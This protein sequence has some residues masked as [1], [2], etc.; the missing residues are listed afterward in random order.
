V[1]STFF[2]HLECSVPCGA[3]PCDPRQTHHRCVCGAPLLARY[4]LTAARRW[5]KSTL[6]GRESSMWRYREILPLLVSSKGVD[7]PVSLGEGWTPLLRARRLGATL[8]LRRLYI[9]DEGQNPTGS[10]KARGFSAAMTRALH[11]GAKVVTVATAGHGAAAA[12]AYAAKAAL[13]AKATVPRDGRRVFELEAGLLRVEITRVDGQVTDAERIVAEQAAANGWYDLSAFREPYRLEGQKTIG[14]ELAEQLG[15]ELPDWILCPVGSGAAFS[16]IWKAFTEMAS[17]GWID[18]VRRPHMVAVQAA[19]CAPIVR[20][21]GSGADH[22][23]AW[24]AAAVR[25]L[26]DD[27]RVPEPAGAPLTLRAIKESAGTAVGAGDTE[28]VA[29]MK[30]LA[31][32]EGVSAAPGGGATLHALR[33]LAGEGRIKPHD[34]VVLINPGTAT[35]FLS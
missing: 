16:G 10:L 14:Y 17:L 20:A 7:P 35:P 34:T 6:V 31:R 9:K 24:G 21:V 12:G 27:L 30:A 13:S 25:T 23:E 18:P 19:G 11:V 3:G 28:M 26:A 29:E 2:S 5:P 4:D 22:A 1:V 33:V 32:Y 8:G 15:W